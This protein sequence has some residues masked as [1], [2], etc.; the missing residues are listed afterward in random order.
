[1]PK[2]ERAGPNVATCVQNM[3]NVANRDDDDDL[4]LPGDVLEELDTL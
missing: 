4:T 2:D 1:V 3:Y